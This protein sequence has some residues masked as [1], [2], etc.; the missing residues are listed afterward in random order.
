MESFDLMIPVRISFL[1][2]E[3]TNVVTS[4]TEQTCLLFFML[5]SATRTVEH[6]GLSHL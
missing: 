4:L 1:Q 5:P 2:D 6:P 3:N